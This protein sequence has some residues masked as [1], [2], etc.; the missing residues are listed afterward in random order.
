MKAYKTMLKTE[1]KLSLRDM[2]MPIFA[3]IMPFIVLVVLG[4]I[5]GSKPAFDGAAAHSWSSHSEQLL[6]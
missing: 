4:V 2:N 1:I 3:I 6:P 5:Y